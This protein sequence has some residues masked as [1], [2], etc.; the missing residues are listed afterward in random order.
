MHVSTL[1]IAL[2]CVL[3]GC[4][5]PQKPVGQFIQNEERELEEDSQHEIEEFNFGPSPGD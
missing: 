5:S 2:C 4:R 1:L 3:G